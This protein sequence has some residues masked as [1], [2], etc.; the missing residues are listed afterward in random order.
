MISIALGMDP[1]QRYIVQDKMSTK[2]AMRITQKCRDSSARPFATA[3]DVLMEGYL[4]QLIEKGE[5]EIEI[6]GAYE[7]LCIASLVRYAIELDINITVPKRHIVRS[8]NN[9][10]GLIRSLEEMN[11]KGF[12]I[13]PFQHTQDSENYFIRFSN[14]LPTSY[15]F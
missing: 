5:D 1:D 10:H 3:H 8:K 4:G 12:K 7:N 15:L 13:V 11:K 9:A 14:E 6:F 2:M